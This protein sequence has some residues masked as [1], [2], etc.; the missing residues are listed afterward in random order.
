MPIVASAVVEV[1]T[2]RKEM[3]DEQ[4]KVEETQKLL[5]VLPNFY[6]VYDWHAAPLDAHQKFSLAWKNFINPV[7]QGIDFGIAGLQYGTN[8]LSGYGL[9][10]GGYFKRFGADTGD[11]GV[12][13]FLGGAVFPVLLR[14]DPRYFYMGPS[15]SK[16]RRF[17]YAL[18]SAVICRGDNGKWQPNYSSVLGDVGSGA[19]S[20]LYYPASNKSGWDVAFYNGLIAAGSDGIGNVVQ[21]FLLKHLTPHAPDYPR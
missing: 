10:V 12:G 21:E 6:V 15:R 13:S 16:K 19:I 17:F 5:G 4:I 9:G 3:A 11:F 18:S 2:S 20:N 7:N 8:Q 1:T 14:Q